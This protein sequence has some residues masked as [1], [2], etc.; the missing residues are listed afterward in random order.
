MTVAIRFG[1]GSPGV[2]CAEHVLFARLATAAHGKA[3]LV[4]KL[5]LYI[6]NVRVNFWGRAS[7]TFWNGGSLVSS[8]SSS[9]LQMQVRSH[10]GLFSTS[11]R[12]KHAERLE[13][14][15]SLNLLCHM[16]SHCK[17]KTQQCHLLEAYH[18]P[19]LVYF[20]CRQIHFVS[21][22]LRAPTFLDHPSMSNACLL[23]CPCFS[24]SWCSLICI[25]SPTP[26]FRL[27]PG[28]S[29]RSTCFVA[30]PRY[31]SIYLCVRFEYQPDGLRHSIVSCSIG[32]LA[33][34]SSNDELRKNCPQTESDTCRQFRFLQKHN[35]ADLQLG[36][37]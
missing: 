9:R 10:A 23:Y 20:F 12:Y 35:L 31:W 16:P 32:K 24:S 3:G 5:V 29:P 30:L 18:T 8:S 22:T 21:C 2:A 7:F 26:N 27:G 4:H 1:I 19:S 34:K 15:V 6:G 33:S 25:C 14:E 11:L 28:Y 17:C 13:S 37:I 36:V